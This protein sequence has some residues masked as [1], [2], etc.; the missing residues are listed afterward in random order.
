[1]S[2]RNKRKIVFTCGCFDLF[3]PGH[4]D[5]LMKASELGN[6][7][8]SIT[9]D[10]SLMKEKSRLPMFNEKARLK[11]MKSLKFVHKAKISSCHLNVIKKLKP[12]YYVKGGDY[13]L[14][15]LNQDEV[16][17]VKSYG[18]KI[19]LIPIVYDVSSTKI[20]KEIKNAT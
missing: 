8:V 2:N 6:L 13:T 4:L 17:Y 20:I 7:I 12:D 10:K 16:N 15:T 9:D 5:Y 3:H 19:V 11:L 14:E 1:M 18:G